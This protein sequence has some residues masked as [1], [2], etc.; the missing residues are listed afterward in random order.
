MADRIDFAGNV[1]RMLASA[2]APR[3]LTRRERAAMQLALEVIRLDVGRAEHAPVEAWLSLSGAS[4]ALRMGEARTVLPVP[5]APLLP[6]G[7]T[8]TDD[9]G[10]I[11]LIRARL[12]LYLRARLRADRGDCGRAWCPGCERRVPLH[13]VS[14]RHC[15]TVHG[16]RRTRLSRRIT[17][18][19]QLAPEHDGRT[20]RERREARGGGRG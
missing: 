5:F 12:A 2:R 3:R 4:S 11:R 20:P 9:S 16:G 15:L 1:R 7:W 19:W 8:L 14:A 6:P 18:L 10:P 13:H 17:P